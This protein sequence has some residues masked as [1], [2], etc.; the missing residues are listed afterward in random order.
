MAGI[1]IHI[2]FCKSRCIYCD[3]FST[4]SLDEREHYV[5]T[6]CKELHIRKDYLPE[7]SRVDT[8]YFGG[9]TPSLLPA[10]QLQ[11]ILDEIHHIYN[12]SPNAEITLEGNPDDLTPRYLK[13][14]YA[15]GFNRLSMGVQTFNDERLHFI[16]RRHSASEA[17][18]AIESARTAGFDNI[19][20]DLMFGFPKETLT[21]WTADIERA[22]SLHPQHISAYSLM[23]EEGTRLTRML[24]ARFI[25]EIDEEVSR[26]MYSTLIE[27]LSTAGYERYEIS[28]FCQPGFHSRHNSSYW[29]GTPYIGVGAAAHSYDGHSR[30]W[31]P[32]SLNV[33]THGI[34]AGEPLFEVETLS[35]NVRYNEYIMTGLRTKRGVCVTH[36]TEQFGTAKANYCLHN[37]KQHISNGTLTL[38]ADHGD[39]QWICLTDEGLY[40]SDD[41]MSDLMCIQSSCSDEDTPPQRHN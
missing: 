16:H 23:Y 18:K 6:V 30:Q 35:D 32:S 26:A 3:F 25:E 37:A 5:S 33:Y 11:R 28:N 40:V 31:N 15:L 21:E 14:V 4:T 2:P 9:G 38:Y 39:R 24:D 41:I 8:V 1:Y 19:S 36:I 29:D 27:R 20:I 34:E 17:V 13:S 10:S 12:V 7:R 22:I